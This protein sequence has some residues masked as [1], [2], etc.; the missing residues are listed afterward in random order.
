MVTH[1]SIGNGPG[2]LRAQYRALPLSARLFSTT[3]PHVLYW[4]AVG[5]VAVFAVLGAC[6][7]PRSIA[8][9]ILIAA[10]GLVG[11]VFPAVAAHWSEQHAELA[12]A[13]VGIQRERRNRL[14]RRHPAYFVVFV[15]IVIAIDASL[16]FNRDRHHPS[17][18]D[19]TVP[20]AVALVFGLVFGSIIIRRARKAQR[21]VP[22][23]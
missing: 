8:G 2:P 22:P 23:E 1:A 12:R 10:I 9:G 7:M 18:L 17:M 16:R 21:S 4:I 3:R 14:A 13:A 6:V 20:A 11:A 15:P 19:W 5:E